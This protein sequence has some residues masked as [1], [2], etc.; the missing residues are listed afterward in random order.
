MGKAP[1]EKAAKAIAIAELPDDE[2]IVYGREL[3]LALDPKMGR[4]ELL[5]RIRQRQELLLELDHEAMLDVVVWA[6][7]PVR[8]S[9][10]KEEL[11]RKIAG[12]RKMDFRGL[13]DRGL[14]V[15]ARLRDV[16]VRT[17]DSRLLM[18]ARLRDAEPVWHRIRRARRKVVGQVLG[19]VV[20][21]TGEEEDE[22][23]RFLPESTAPTSTLRD[24]IAEQGVVG[25]IAYRLRSVADDYVREKLDEIETRIDLKLDEIDARLAEWRDKEI[26]NRLRIL[27]IT[28]VVSVFVALL[29]LGYNLVNRMN[30]PPPPAPAPPAERIEPAPGFGL[31]D[32]PCSLGEPWV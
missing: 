21:D 30:A 17:T 25:G 23:Y 28:L 22:S 20:G 13:S 32:P 24:H 12:T 29:S 7:V 4:G 2:L 11:A 5:R 16:P 26:A 27:K 19:M 9:A 3:G 18:A 14:Y 31:A 6:R 15:L 1:S 8:K 10:G